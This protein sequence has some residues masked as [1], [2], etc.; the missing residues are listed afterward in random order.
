MGCGALVVGVCGISMHDLF[1]PFDDY[2]GCIYVCI[3]DEIM[4]S[5]NWSLTVEGKVCEMCLA[6]ILERGKQ[7]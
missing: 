5:I 3:Y 1:T 6:F 2:D 7:S 4:K